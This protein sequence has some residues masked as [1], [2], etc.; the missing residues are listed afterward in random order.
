MAARALLT[1]P[2]ALALAQGQASPSPGPLSVQVGL[3]SYRGDGSNG[4]SA[5]TGG[6]TGEF[7]GNLYATSGCSLGAGS[8]EAPAAAAD[9]WRVSG[10]IVDMTA[11]SAVVDLLWSRVKD[12]GQPSAASATQRLSLQVNDPVTVDTALIAPQGTCDVVR[13]ALEARLAPRLRVSG[14]GGGRYVGTTTG[15]TA[16]SGGGGGATTNAGARVEV[17]R[18][19]GATAGV[20]RGGAQPGSDEYEVE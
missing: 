15:G 14:S 5:S 17:E 6:V 16:K 1:I 19:S 7:E 20:G 12:G 18:S 2:I 3:F 9:V 13:V 11:D 10:K 4:G 8:R